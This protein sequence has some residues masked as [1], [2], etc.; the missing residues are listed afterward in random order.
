MR[1]QA[2]SLALSLVTLFSPV[3]L[4][5]GGLGDLRET[6]KSPVENLETRERELTARAGDL[7]T[8]GELTQALFLPEWRDNDLEPNLAATDRRVWLALSERFTLIIRAGLEAKQLPEEIEAINAIASA[9]GMAR[10]TSRRFEFIRGFMPDLMRLMKGRET[11]VACAAAR[12]LARIR[13]I[14]QDAISAFRA[15]LTSE[16]MERREAAADG[17]TQWIHNT[18]VL[19]RQGQNTMQADATRAETGIVGSLIVPVAARGLVDD[20]AEVRRGAIRAFL[21]SAAAAS[22]L[23]RD[24][25]PSP[26]KLAGLEYAREV[27]AEQTALRPLV[28]TLQA[29]AQFVGRAL[30]DFDPE[31]RQTALHALEETAHARRRLLDRAASAQAG[32]GTKLVGEKAPGEGMPISAIAALLRQKDTRVRLAALDILEAVGSAAESAAPAIVRQLSDSN[33]FVRWAAARALAKIGPADAEHAVPALTQMLSDPDSDLQIIA[34]TALAMYGP[35]AS[36]ALLPLTAALAS[37]NPALRVVALHALDRIGPDAAPALAAIRD[38]LEDRDT[39]VRASA[40]RLLGKFGPSARDSLN[41]LHSRLD[42]SSPAVRSAAQ[43]AMR[44][45]AEPN[46]DR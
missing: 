3:Y 19:A 25:A 34:A 8:L 27:E 14:P 24:V 39:Q 5:A 12:A 26:D 22:V 29:H 18:A 10:T 40:A 35:A 17:L 31:V 6:L 32:A 44:R 30:Q 37:E 36:S 15:L 45:I 38:A 16:D 42:D 2:C 7:H 20:C 9:G 23:V 13:P 41:S 21:E 46:R 1:F 28:L 11:Q 33:Q 4:R 43:E